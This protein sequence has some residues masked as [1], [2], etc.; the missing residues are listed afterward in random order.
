MMK[1]LFF[2]EYSQ[3]TFYT[4]FIFFFN[5]ECLHFHLSIHLFKT[6]YRKT[7]YYMKL[8]LIMSDKIHRNFVIYF[9]FLQQLSSTSR[10]CLPMSPTYQGLQLSQT[11]PRSTLHFLGNH[12]FL[13][14]HPHPSVSIHLALL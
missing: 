14:E 1:K 4:C 11:P 5:F 8:L 13:L 12:P 7:T 6:T 9:S 10:P 3:V 2:S